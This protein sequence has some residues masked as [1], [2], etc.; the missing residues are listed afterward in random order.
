[1]GGLYW[2]VVNRSMD[3]DALS[4]YEPLVWSGFLAVSPGRQAA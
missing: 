1:M 3:T 2:L 4:P